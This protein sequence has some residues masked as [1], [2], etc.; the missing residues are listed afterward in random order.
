M[1]SADKGKLVSA[2]FGNGTVLRQVGDHGVII[3]ALQ[4]YHQRS[5]DNHDGEDQHQ[6]PVD[7]Y[8]D[9]VPLARN[10]VRCLFL[11]NVLANKP[12]QRQL[13]CHECLQLCTVAI[14]LLSKDFSGLF[15]GCLGYVGHGWVAICENGFSFRVGK[16]DF[17]VGLLWVLVISTH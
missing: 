8:R 2:V 1:F 5:H 17:V 14:V 4:K 9:I 16:S 12:E 7:D 10:G 6:Q 15:V 3:W 13:L 11:L